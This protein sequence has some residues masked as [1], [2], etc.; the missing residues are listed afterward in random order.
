MQWTNATNYQNTD[1]QT[2][3]VYSDVKTSYSANRFEQ[4][5][6]EFSLSSIQ[7]RLG[8]VSPI[9][10]VDVNTASADV[11]PSSQTLNMSY[12]RNY[13][14]NTKTVS[15]FGTKAK[16]MVAG[17]AVIVLGLIIAVALCSVSV[18]GAFSTAAALNAEYI[19]TSAQ[20]A[21]LSEQLQADNYD[22]LFEKATQ[23]GYVEASKSNTQTYTQIETRPAQNFEVQ[24]NW[25]DS[26]CDWL[27]GVFG[28]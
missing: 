14:E 9:E 16:L 18:G 27:S 11:M 1:A 7:E 23:L 6:Q 8:I 12:T 10:D 28:G 22:V 26:L 20:V 15:K 19:E 21:E 5:N 25:F 3:D 4:D 17:Y 13:S 2:A 24:T